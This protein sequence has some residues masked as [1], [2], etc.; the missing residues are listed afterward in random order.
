MSHAGQLLAESETL[1]S[2]DKRL[3]EIICTNS[4]RVSTIINNVLH[5]S[6]REETHLERLSLLGWIEEFRDDFCATMQLP[7]E[8]LSIT[9]V[10]MQ[11]AVRVDASQLRQVV[12][13]L[14]DNVLRHASVA[15]PDLPIELRFGRLGPGLRP[16]LDI[17]D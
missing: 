14:C 6:R 3:T 10:E 12:W 8:R 2:E 9:G 15:S 13:N 4:A 11:L 1:G 17:A 16:Y 7:P 5:L